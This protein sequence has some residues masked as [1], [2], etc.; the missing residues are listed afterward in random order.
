LEEGRGTGEALDGYFGVV[1][2]RKLGGERAS[3]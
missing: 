3:L 1:T 2:G